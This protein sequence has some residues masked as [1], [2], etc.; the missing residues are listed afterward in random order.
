MFQNSN[1]PRGNVQEGNAYFS[2]KNKLYGFKVEVSVLP[3][4]QAINC[5]Q[6]FAGSVSYIDIFYHNLR[7]HQQAS[8]KTAEETEDIDEDLFPIAILAYWG[9]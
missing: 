8:V 5:T 7:F 9:W 6:Q 2:G 3:N 4:G 1:R